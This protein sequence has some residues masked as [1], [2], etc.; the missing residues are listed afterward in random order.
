MFKSV[1][2]TLGCTFLLTGCVATAGR[3]FQRPPPETLVL[4]QTTA[5]EVE[6]RMGA[7]FTQSTNTVSDPTE[8]QRAKLT[9]FSAMPTPSTRTFIDYAYGQ[10]QMR[11]ELAFIFVDSRLAA[12]TFRS[13]FP[14]DNSDFDAGKVSLLRKGETTE[15]EAISLFGP[16]YG[17]A[18]Y[19]LV[20]DP[21]NHIVRYYFNSIV[22]THHN[23]KELDLLADS[24]NRVID[25]KIDSV[26]DE[27]SL[28][29]ARGVT[30]VPI[31]IPRGK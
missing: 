17:R 10:G 27:V 2:A 15:A 13:D 9:E 16:Q 11:R 18:T 7:P 12:Y 4:G 14:N 6:G 22:G 3:D 19:P 5:S 29:A 20:R 8:E 25:Y 28:P 30:S 1:A 23:A 26:S 24:R 21:G 31:F